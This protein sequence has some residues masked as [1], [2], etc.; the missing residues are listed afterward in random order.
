MG[1][2]HEMAAIQA[3]VVWGLIRQI[4]QR[5]VPIVAWT[6]VTRPDEYR[7][8]VLISTQGCWTTIP[9]INI[10]GPLEKIAEQLIV[11]MPRFEQAHVPS[12]PEEVPQLN[13]REWQWFQ[14]L[15]WLREQNRF[16]EWAECRASECAH[17]V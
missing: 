3:D 13:E 11:G 5:G 14:F 10:T 7:M 8:L 15:R 9:I 2:C 1:G 17:A 6:I 12:A 16:H 4:C